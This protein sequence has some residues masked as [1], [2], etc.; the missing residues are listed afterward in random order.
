MPDILINNAGITDDDL[1]IRMSDEKWQKVINTN[2]TSVMKITKLA[3]KPMLRKK[4]GRIV[5][6]SSV[7][8][9]SGNP[10]QTN[11]CA[12][13]AGVIAMSKSL[14]LE[15][16]SRSRDI[17]VNVVSPGFIETDMTKKLTD[18]QRNNIQSN[19]PMQRMGSADDIAH[20]AV[21]LSSKE[22]SYITGHVLHVNGGLWMGG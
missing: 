22:S 2:L 6:I 14:A 17:T 13:K 5:N 16:S 4:W 21:F 12:A 18:E 3:L 20:A 15:V 10:G 8:A 11:Y 19:I 9:S 1:F 7:V